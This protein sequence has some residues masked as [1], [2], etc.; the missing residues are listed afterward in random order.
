M[1]HVLPLSAVR[2]IIPLRRSPPDATQKAVDG[3]LSP[4]SRA[5]GEGNGP[6][7]QNDPGSDDP[8]RSPSPKAVHRVVDEQLMDRGEPIAVVADKADQVAPRSSVT[9]MLV[10]VATRHRLAKGHAMAFG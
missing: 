3:Q 4:A 6:T 8:A 7:V 1:L 9:K 2:R 5:G 10:L